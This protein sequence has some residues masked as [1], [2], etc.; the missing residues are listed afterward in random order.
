VALYLLLCQSACVSRVGVPW[1]A[2]HETTPG[3]YA[4]THVRGEAG[5]RLCVR[6]TYVL[7]VFFPD[8]YISPQKTRQ[9]RK[10]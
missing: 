10:K 9:E 1:Y 5:G 7:R 3:E 4:S 2:S 8:E 6:M